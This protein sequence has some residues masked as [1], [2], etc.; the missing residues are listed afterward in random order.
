MM[1][2]DDLLALNYLLTR[3]EVDPTRVGVTGMSLGGS[4]A[5]WIGALDERP[6]IVV[7][8]G[9]MT[10][11][12]DFAATG[13]YNLHSIYYYLPGLLKS[14]LDMEHLVALVAPRNQA[15]LIGEEDPLSPIAGVH[16]VLDYARQVYNLYDAGEQLQAMIE[17]GVGH[18]FT[19]TMFQT[20]LAAM[21]RAL[22]NG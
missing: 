1:V 13:R 6:R 7:P 18:Q 3:Q 15:I 20:M 12:R 17:P 21:N 2:R 22:G 11:Y 8:M 5:T 10:R 4:R 9:Q 19:L 16:T 14:D